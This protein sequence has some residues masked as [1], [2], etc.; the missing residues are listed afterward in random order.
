MITS[1]PTKRVSA[2][3]QRKTLIRVLPTGWRRKPAV[4]EVTSVTLCILWFHV[5]LRSL[6]IT[7]RSHALR[8]SRWH[9]L[10]AAPT[11][12]SAWNHLVPFDF[13]ILQRSY[14]PHT[15]L[16][17]L[18]IY[19]TTTYTHPFNGPLSRTT[20]VSRYQK[21]KTNLD[22]TEARD[23]EWQWNQLGCTSLQTDNHTSTPPLFITLPVGQ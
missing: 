9:R 8:A 12:D 23:S 20:R 17:V 2:L 10:H 11:T 4:T 19:H 21:G 1:L 15:G 7:S 18:I 13:G 5:G 6:Y 16:V 3:S 22:F 14:Y